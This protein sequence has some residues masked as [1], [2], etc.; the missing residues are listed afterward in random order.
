MTNPYEQGN[1][2]IVW[3]EPHLTGIK[4]LDEQ[5]RA[6][7]SII[8]ALHYALYVWPGEDLLRSTAEMING[9]THLHFRTEIQM[10]KDSEYPR[11]EQH[12]AQ[13]DRLIADADHIFL[14]CLKEGGDPAPF[15]EFLKDWWK[16]HIIHEDMAYGEHLLE[17]LQGQPSVIKKFV[18]ED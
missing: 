10:L 6:I 8:N 18:R 1:L 5:H 7:V 11:L 16:N 2:L 15:L 17:Y 9:Y 14:R 3:R 13:H 4:I 12:Q